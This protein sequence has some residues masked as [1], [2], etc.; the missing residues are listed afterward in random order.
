MRD[1]VSEVL[2]PMGG[3][4]S[5]P[6]QESA[7]GFRQPP[8]DTRSFGRQAKIRTLWRTVP[9]ERFGHGQRRHE[10]MPNC[11]E[12]TQVIFHRLHLLNVSS[13]SPPFPPQIQTGRSTS[14]RF[15]QSLSLLGSARLSL[16]WQPRLRSAARSL[17]GLVVDLEWP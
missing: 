6:W 5:C 10:V 2:V 17:R 8:R 3:V 4:S 7:D 9:S 11:A 16:R 12:L 1:R 15:L 14:T 13:Y